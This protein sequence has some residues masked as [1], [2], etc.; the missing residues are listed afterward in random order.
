MQNI[1]K[2]LFTLCMSSNGLHRH[3]LQKSGSCYGPAAEREYAS[4]QGSAHAKLPMVASGPYKRMRPACLVAQ[5]FVVSAQ[6]IRDENYDTLYT[7]MTRNKN[8]LVARVVFSVSKPFQVSLYPFHHPCLLSG[9]E[10]HSK[11]QRF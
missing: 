11:G 6:R 3:L 5:V 9:S 7:L 10:F 4:L 1:Q 2:L 8:G